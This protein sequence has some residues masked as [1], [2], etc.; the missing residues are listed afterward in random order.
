MAEREEEMQGRRGGSAE[1]Y[2]RPPYAVEGRPESAHWFTD[3]VRWSSVWAGLV[4]A[5]ATQLVLAS[6]VFAIVASATP[7]VAPDPGAVGLWTAIMALIALFLGGWTAA[8]LA[9]ITGRWNGIW[10]GVVVWA[11]ALTLGSVA[12]ALGI[13][14]VLGYTG[15]PI[16]GAAQQQLGQ[17]MGTAITGAW[18]FFI[19]AILALLAAALGGLAGSRPVETT[20]TEARATA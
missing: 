3:R 13:G 15:M 10:N 1:P 8:R 4:V 19:G 16:T 12:A 11:L 6:L 2:V 7:G 20:E 14:G 17:I 18:W 5:F 9:G